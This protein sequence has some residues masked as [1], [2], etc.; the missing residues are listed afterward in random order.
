[1]KTRAPN[2]P[3]ME[4]I[5]HQSAPSIEDAAMRETPSFADRPK[6]I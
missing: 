3:P 1:M 2:M 6:A 5:S 4:K